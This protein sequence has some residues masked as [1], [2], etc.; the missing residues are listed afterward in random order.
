MITL[1]FYLSGQY[2]NTTGTT[3]GDKY[4]RAS[5]RL[6]GTRKVGESKYYVHCGY[7]QNR[8]DITTQTGSMYGNMLNMPSNVDITKYKNWRTDPFA[9]PNGYYNPWY[10]NPYFTADNWRVQ[11]R[12]D[13]LTVTW[14]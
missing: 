7:T 9:N 6:N 4:N 14:N 8:Y 13:Y 1:H 2:V 3:P 10:Q 11:A 5:L 12:N